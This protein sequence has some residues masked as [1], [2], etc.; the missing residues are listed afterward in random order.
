MYEKAVQHHERAREAGIRLDPLQK[1]VCLSRLG[2]Y[3]DALECDL[4]EQDPTT[5]FM[6]GTLYVKLEQCDKAIELYHRCI[7]KN[8][9][10]PLNYGGMADALCAS[11]YLVDALE[12]YD[13]A[14]DCEKR[15]SGPKTIFHEKKVKVLTDLG[16]VDDALACCEDALGMKQTR[17]IRLLKSELLNK[18]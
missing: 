4:P 14:I 7:E 9:E 10:C 17:A 1:F 8:P 18:K 13:R 11:G 2:R 15:K 3:E 6:H 5:W 16:L 12:W